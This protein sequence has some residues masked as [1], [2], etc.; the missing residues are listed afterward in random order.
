MNPKTRIF[1][2][3]ELWKKWSVNRNDLLFIFVVLWFLFSGGYIFWDQW[4]RF[5][6][7]ELRGAYNQGMIDAGTAIFKEAGLCKPFTISLDQQE[8]SLIRTDCPK[9]PEPRGSSEIG[10]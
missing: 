10:E 4:S 1:S 9:N 3:L 2:S 8:I 6:N 5:K 7:R